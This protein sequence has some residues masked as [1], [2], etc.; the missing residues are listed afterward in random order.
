MSI[1]AVYRHKLRQQQTGNYLHNMSAPPRCKITMKPIP[2]S[3]V[4]WRDGCDLKLKSVGENSR[5]AAGLQWVARVDLDALIQ[6]R[7]PDFAV[8]RAGAG[9]KTPLLSRNKYKYPAHARLLCCLVIGRN[10][11]DGESKF[12]CKDVEVLETLSFD[13]IC[14]ELR[15]ITTKTNAEAAS[16]PSM[17]IAIAADKEKRPAETSAIR[18]FH[19]LS[20]LSGSTF[21]RDGTAMITGR[22]DSN[23]RLDLWVP[24]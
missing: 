4:Q 11:E 10:I 9:F 20:R 23:I 18:T 3:A 8:T 7:F 15:N 6:S 14:D 21:A 5:S 12:T 2:Q 1:L 19:I 24:A 17:G 16:L 13:Q 22:L